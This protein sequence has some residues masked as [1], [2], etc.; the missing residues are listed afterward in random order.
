MNDSQARLTFRNGDQSDSLHNG[1]EVLD[2][3]D[4]DN[5]VGITGAEIDRGIE[6]RIVDRAPRGYDL[7]LTF[8]TRG[9]GSKVGARAEREIFHYQRVVDVDI[10]RRR[11]RRSMD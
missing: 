7:D 9:E 8:V 11:I 2:H 4:R 10:D 1:I 6:E 5:V 3:V